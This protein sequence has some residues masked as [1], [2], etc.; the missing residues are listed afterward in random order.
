M[1]MYAMK[2]TG[3]VR[4]AVTNL[5]EFAEMLQKAKAEADQLNQPIR[6]LSSFCLDIQFSIGDDQAGSISDALSTSSSMAT[7]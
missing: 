6:N 2:E 1:D 3:T 4:I 7:K 5:E